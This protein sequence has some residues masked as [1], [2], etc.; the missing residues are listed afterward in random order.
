M[1]AS[2]IFDIVNRHLPDV[3]CYADDTQLYL[4]FNPTNLANQQEAINAMESCIRDIKSWMCSDKLK[5]NDDKT[6][7]IIISTQQ[8]LS[9][10]KINNIVIGESEIKPVSSV[11]N[12]G[13]WFDDK[14][15]MAIHITKMCS[16]SFYHLHNIRRIRKYLSQDAAESLI[17]S[18]ITSRVDYCN[19][20][21]YSVPAYQ[22]EK[23]QR[24]QNDATRLIFKEHK[25]CHITPLL[26][27]LHWL[28][29]KFRI[30]FK[31]L[32]IT[33]KAIHGLAPMYVQ[34][35]ISTK[36]NGRYALHSSSEIL[37]K[38][39]A[40]KTLATLGDCAFMVAA[41]KL[42]NVLPVDICDANNVDNFKRLLKT[43]FF[44]LA[45]T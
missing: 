27:N 5:L 33:F 23:L 36:L 18:F 25:F 37:L 34:D 28:P 22:L 4:S 40:C 2:K 39:P 17:H 45:Y 12:L 41:P 9:K 31:I 42:W 26:Q 13:A 19:S 24:V 6:E 10:V 32:L 30:N 38:S 43:Y 35:L 16:S 29:V 20:L 7:F 15:S 11:R 14:C 44:K 21:L 1:Y 3:H 8:Q